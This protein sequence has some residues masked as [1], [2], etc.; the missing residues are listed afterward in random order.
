M[1][2]EQKTPVQSLLA[3]GACQFCKRT[4]WTFLIGGIASV[5]F[6][7]LAFMNPGVALFV[8]GIFLAAYLL[9]DGAVNIWG[10]ISNRDK[11]GWWVALLLGVAGVVVG[12]YALFVPIVSMLAIVYM[13]AFIAMLIGVSS[14]YLGWRIR[15]EVSS[16]W[17]LYVT[18]ILSV[19]FSLMI[20]F[21]PGIGSVS[22]VYLI[23]TWAVIIGVLRIFFGFRIRKLGKR[24]E[25]TADAGA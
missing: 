16:E 8:L 6:G 17:V 24:I 21:R 10:A 7:V 15:K 18:G 13:V 22:V 1:T 23:A 3:D 2:Q 25:S 9:V 19:L 4:W 14:L 20:L 12:G 11:D 5:A